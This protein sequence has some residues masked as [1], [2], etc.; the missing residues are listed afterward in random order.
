MMQLDHQKI[1][2]R[3]CFLRNFSQLML[4]HF[5]MRL[6]FDPINLFPVFQRPNVSKKLNDRTCT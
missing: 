6:I 3:R 5:A 4:S 2:A 1:E